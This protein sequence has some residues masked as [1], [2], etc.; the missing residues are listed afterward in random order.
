MNTT[1]PLA[2]Y[3]RVLGTA[4]V[5]VLPI[6]PIGAQQ[7][8]TA[9]ASASN[10]GTLVVTPERPY[11]PATAH[12]P[13]AIIRRSLRLKLDAAPAP[14]GAPTA[15]TRSPAVPLDTPPPVYPPRALAA[16]RS[17]EVTVRFTVRPDGST[18]DVRIVRAS[19]P[20]LF[21]AA[22][23]DAVRSWRFRPA[24]AEGHAVATTVTQT[25]I[26]Q[27]P[28]PSRKA[29]RAA[30]PQPAPRAPGN[31]VPANVHPLHLVPPT[32]PPQAF[33]DGLAGRVTVRFIVARDGHTTA[34]RILAAHPPGV[35]DNAVLRA[36]RQ[37]RFAPVSIP[38]PVTQ[39]L[40]FTP[41]SG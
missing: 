33:Q 30:P 13:A 6:A 26:F 38:T 32:Y 20:H 8:T 24:N 5:V 21:D 35:F 23:R 14:P 7:T 15:A 34:V 28:A 4:A 3:A 18:G 37:W 25:L 2:R 29:P 39:T 31:S 19:P 40:T 9:P 16:H 41:G 17:G 10:L 11:Q 1:S 12:R 27:P 36:V 22:A